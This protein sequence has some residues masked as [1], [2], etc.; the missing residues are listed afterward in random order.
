MERQSRAEGG[1]DSARGVAAAVLFSHGLLDPAVE[2]S[3]LKIAPSVFVA[4]PYYGT[5]ISGAKTFKTPTITPCFRT[6][7][8]P[9]L[10]NYYPRRCGGWSPITMMREFRRQ[11]ERLELLSQYDT[12]VTLSRHMQR[13][14]TSHGL[15]A[16]WVQGATG[17][18]GID[19][20]AMRDDPER[21]GERKEWKLLFAGRMEQLKGGAYFIAALP[22]VASALDR[23][24]NVIFAGDGPARLSWETAAREM[25]SRLPELRFQF[26]GWLGT[27]RV[28]ALLAGADLLVMPSVWPEPFGLVGLEAGRHKLPVAAFAV[29]GIPEWLRPGINGYLAPGDP[30][31]SNGLA[32]AIVA[33][34]K[35]AE[36]YAR[37]RE[38]AGRIAAEFDFERHVDALIRTLQE[39]SES[40]LSGV[41]YQ[42][43]P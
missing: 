17:Q 32:D 29:G 16:V 28:D 33:C 36:A 14:Y 35:D 25:A 6:F 5:C 8:W 37:L 15:N 12:I 31:T 9:C 24:L 27:D 13:E 41:R 22:R 1:A 40:Q 4:H 3:V 20:P 11:A 43:R 10:V 2:R 26:T 39:A 7:G 34:L 23:R 38:G 30:P 42:P 19:E 18:C 21:E